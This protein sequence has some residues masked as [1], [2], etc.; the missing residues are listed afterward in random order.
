MKL[1]VAVVEDEELIRTML[2]LNLER[3]DYDVVEYVDAESLL[4]NLQSEAFDIVLLDIM[5][6]GMNGEDCLRVLRSRFA[7]LP[8]LMLTAK[9][10]MDTKVRSLDTGADDYL[11]KPFDMAEVLARVRALIRRSQGERAV[12]SD[13]LVRIGGSVVELDSRSAQTT[14]GPVKLSDREAALLELFQRSRGR[15]LTRD[16]ILEEVWGLDADPTP[17]TVDNYIVRLRKLFEEDPECP[18]HFLT[19]RSAGYRFE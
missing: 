16:E 15:T 4:A 11:V 17:R 2:R 13:R 18:R 6:P 19:V 14:R 5:L 10:D 7:S 1:R 8:V 3:A 9:K 12:S